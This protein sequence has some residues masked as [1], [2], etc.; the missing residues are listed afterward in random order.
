M[1]TA[2]A[3]VDTVVAELADTVLAKSLEPENIVLPGRPL[4]TANLTNKQ[5]ARVSIITV[6]GSTFQRDLGRAGVAGI[7]FVPTRSTGQVS[8]QL[9]QPVDSNPA[10]SGYTSFLDIADALTK[11]FAWQQIRRANDNGIFLIQFET[12]SIDTGGPTD[13]HNMMIVWC[14]FYV[15][16]PLKEA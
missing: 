14:P 5:W 16:G 9:F 7:G 6:P 11:H 4:E 1:A 10:R 15:E 2:M 13:T 8:I 3:L 12:P